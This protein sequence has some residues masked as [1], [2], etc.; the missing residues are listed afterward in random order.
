[1]NNQTA[2]HHGSHYSVVT[3]SNL[4]QFRNGLTSSFAPTLQLEPVLAPITALIQQAEDWIFAELTVGWKPTYGFDDEGR[5]VFDPAIDVDRIPTRTFPFSRL[6]TSCAALGVFLLMSFVGLLLLKCC[7]CGGDGPFVS[8]RVLYPLK[9]VY[10][11]VQI[12]LCSYMTL[13]AVILAHRNGYGWWPWTQC[14]VF[15]FQDPAIHRLIWVYYMSK[16]LDWADTLFIILG[17]K[18]RQ[19]T[20]LHIYHHASVWFFNWL[21]LVINFDAEIFIAVGFNAAI[22]V[23]MYTYYLISMHMPK[24]K[25][26]RTGKSKYSVWWKQHLTTLQMTQ[27]FGMNLHGFLILYNGCNQV[28]PRGTALYLAYIMSL[29]LLF[30]NFF[31]RSY[32]GG[33]SKKVSRRKKRQ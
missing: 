9:F 20:V 3:T 14:N 31:L 5:M 25:D 11:F 13:E 30:L 4:I 24:V 29:F 33:K 1:M 22:H 28:T 32:C 10:N 18:P 19:F 27:F 23:I 2:A 21:N 16:M 7:R 17:N 12:Y 6:T 15:N 26:E 8:Q